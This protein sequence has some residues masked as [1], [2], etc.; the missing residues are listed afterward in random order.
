MVW[1]YSR[2]VRAGRLLQL[3]VLLQIRGRAS[4]GELA[5]LL[6]VSVRTV[7][8]DVL[9][10]MA[11]GVPLHTEVGRNGGIR[12]DPSYRVAGLPRID[13]TDAR[14]L[15]FAAVPSI[16]GQLGFDP[17][18]TD[19]T[20]L[21]AMEA[22]AESAAR[23]VKER[24]LIEPD[25]WFRP[26]DDT[27]ALAEV[28]R[29]VWESRELRLTYR[30]SDVVTQPLGL[31]LKGDTW[32]LLGHTDGQD[33][34]FRVSRID[35]VTVLDHQVEV[36]PD[37][38]LAAAWAARRQAFLD[39]IPRYLV[40]VRV[41]PRAEPLL[42]LL[43]EGTPELPLSADVER[44]DDGW[45]RLTLRFERPASAARLLLQ[46][47]ADIEVIDPPDVRQLMEAAAGGLHALY[48]DCGTQKL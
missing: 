45:A 14:S 36:A 16:A 32:Y 9:A 10:L 11:A 43:Q 15:L 41:A 12:I 35:D 42:G 26:P 21:P 40:M 13:A 30:G 34:L 33:R 8:R 47:G 7:H 5:E 6:E 28:A 18:V 44:D 39:S 29:A 20:L 17:T 24:L 19:R 46:L 31:I 25:D 23:A 48:V 4:A 22:R 3:L 1:E 2:S 38:D 27:P 37:F